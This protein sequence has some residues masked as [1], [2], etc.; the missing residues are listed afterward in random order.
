MVTPN[1]CSNLNKT[2]KCIRKSDKKTFLLPRRFSKKQ[3]KKPRGFTM[4]SSCAPYKDCFKGGSKELNIHNN[5]LEIC[6]LNPL[7][8]YPANNNLLSVSVITDKASTADALATSFMV[9]GKSKSIAYI[10]ELEKAQFQVYMIYDS[11]GEYKEWS[12]Y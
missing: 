2:K 11:L 4:R 12:N 9:M 8:G 3:C 1:C 10:N 6:S 7:T 5:L